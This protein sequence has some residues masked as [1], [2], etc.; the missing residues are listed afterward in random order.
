MERRAIRGQLLHAV[1]RAQGDVDETLGVD[2]DG[3]RALRAL[4]GAAECLVA[5]GEVAQATTHYRELLRLNPGDNQGNRYMLAQLL[6]KQELDDEVERLLNSYHEDSAAWLYTRALLE[7][8]RRGPGKVAT[9][10][11]IKAFDQNR[12]VPLYLTA[13]KKP[14]RQLPGF[15]G[16]GDENEAIH[17]FVDSVEGWLDTPGALPW[18]VSVLADAVGESA[19]SRPS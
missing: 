6:L 1:L 12:F 9:K 17:Y 10:A 7:Y 11:L 4:A 15:M 13:M 2:R 3:V 5:I 8:R 19:E 14:P 18:F 16:I